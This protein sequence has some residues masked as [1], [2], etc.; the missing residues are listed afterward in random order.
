MDRSQRIVCDLTLDSNETIVLVDTILCNET[1][2]SVKTIVLVETST[3]DERS[4]CDE[5]IGQ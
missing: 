2:D 3:C 5:R 1:I 4:A